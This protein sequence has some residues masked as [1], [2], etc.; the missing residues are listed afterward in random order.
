MSITLRTDED[1]DAA[2]TRLAAA[3]GRSRQ[4]TLKK[5]ILERDAQL[6]RASRLREIS[7]RGLVKW[8]GVYERL[9]EM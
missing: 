3:E 7:Q 9:A 6:T 5:L 8:A 1:L 4:E 2:L